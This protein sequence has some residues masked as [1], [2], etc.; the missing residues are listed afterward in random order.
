MATSTQLLDVARTH[1]GKPY[2]LVGRFGPDA[3]DCSG[4]VH[5]ALSAVG[6]DSPTVSSTLWSWCKQA[7]LEVPIWTAPPG[8]LLFMPENP[9]LGIGPSGHVALVDHFGWT[10]EARGRA[11]GVGSWPIAGRKWSSHA[12]LIPGITYPASQPAPAPSD[13][14][15]KA[16]VAAIA[17]LVEDKKN[18]TFVDAIAKL[19]FV[20]ALAAAK[21]QKQIEAWNTLMFWL[22]KK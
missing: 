11:W 1:W 15:A 8:A 9:S 5:A 19:Q 21:R 18:Q 12:A 16:F 10:S 7:G 3:Y 4:H 17:K 20:Q 22:G 14:E 2:R 13:A 6:I